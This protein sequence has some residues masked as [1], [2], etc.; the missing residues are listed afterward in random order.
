MYLCIFLVFLSISINFSYAFRVFN[1]TI[2]I[3]LYNDISL[4]A[5]KNPN[6][7]HND[8]FLQWEAEELELYKQDRLAKTDDDDDTDFES[9]DEG[10]LTSTKSKSDRLGK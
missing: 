2:R 10:Y 1:P 4:R 7:E 6:I 9:N 3:R 8:Q 5:D